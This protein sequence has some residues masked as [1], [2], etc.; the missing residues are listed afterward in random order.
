MD[1]IIMHVDLDAFFAACEERENPKLKG[2]PVIIGAD[3]KNGSGRGV[4]STANYEAR[5]FGIKSAMPI[6]RAFRLCPDG[7]YLRPNFS[8]YENV[9]GKVMEIL[10]KHAD[11][12]QQAGI[13]EAFL[14]VSSSGSYEKAEKIASKLK[15]EKKETQDVTASVGIAPNKMVAKI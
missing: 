10:K 12:F 11:K 6:S 8:L 2:R 1:R 13:D 7:T 4:V 5:K 3:P 14:D 9:S 15:N